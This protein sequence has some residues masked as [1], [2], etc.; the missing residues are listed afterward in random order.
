MTARAERIAALVIAALALVGLYLTS[1]IDLSLTSNLNVLTGPRGYPGLILGGILIL[2]L[3]VAARPGS[4]PAIGTASS[5]TIDQHR[6]G[7]LRVGLVLAALVLFALAFEP[8]GYILAMPPLLVAI[9]ILSGAQRWQSA[10]LVSVLMALICLL[11]FRFGL[12][13]VL[14]EGVLGIDL[15][16]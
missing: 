2:A 10:A 3:I 12:D 4:F 13:T 15:I 1:R 7:R 11:A 5:E 6:G 16:L 9:A 14:P 8:L